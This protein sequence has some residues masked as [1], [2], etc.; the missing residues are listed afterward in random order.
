MKPKIIIILILIIFCS[1]TKT[2]KSYSTKNISSYPEKSFK[3]KKQLNSETINNIPDSILLPFKM[4]LINNHLLLM[5]SKGNKFVHLIDIVEEKYL[6]SFIDKGQGP[7][8]VQVPWNISKIDDNSFLIYDVAGKK[9]LGFN[10][11][12]LLLKEERKAIFEKKINEKDICSSVQMVKGNVYYTQDL[13]A[14]YRL[15]KLDTLSNKEH[16]Y[17]K[18]INNFNNIKDFNFG[19]ACRAVTNNNKGIFVTAYQLAPFFEIY[20]SQTN[21]WK[22]ILSIDEFSPIYREMESE[23]NMLFGVTKD[24][25]LGFIDISMSEKY[26][27][28]LYS[29][30]IMLDRKSDEANKVLVFDYEGNPVAI[31]KLNNYISAFKVHEDSIIYGLKNNIKV[32]LVKFYINQ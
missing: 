20:N 10:I 25:K 31:Y 15:Y 9:I 22:S 3:I 13:K 19:Q 12:S 5:D 2:D 17:G 26:I 4:E 29:G 32:E 7:G 11:D 1:C 30:E 27:Y 24:T 28:L 23:G 6:G 18:L 14:N 21:S 16:G 8:E